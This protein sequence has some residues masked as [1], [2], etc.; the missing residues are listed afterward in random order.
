MKNK[1]GHYFWS[2]LIFLLAAFCLSLWLT[3]LPQGDAAAIIFWQIRLPR[4]VLAALVGASLAVSGVIFQAVLRNPLADPYLLGVS[5]GAGLG[6]A[7]AL[8]LGWSFWFWG[9]SAVSLLAL[10]GALAA[11]FI[12]YRLSLVSG[13]SQI[14]TLILAGVAVSAFLSAALALTVILSGKIWPIQ[15]W[16]M[17]NFTD[18]SWEKVVLVAPYFAVCF[19]L[20]FI[21]ARRLDVL[22]L[23]E[24]E[25]AALGAGGERVKIFF[26]MLGTILAAASVAAVGLIGF[27][28]L[29][30]PH[31]IRRLSGALNRRLISNS[32][33]AGA[34]F[35]V[36]ADYLARTIFSPQEL[37]VGL[38]T[39]F[40]GAPFFLYLLRREKLDA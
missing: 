26:I 36:L 12:I 31:V 15:L 16:L 37:P 4:V 34:V 29:V 25:A 13:T 14:T 27:V 3:G 7:L 17:G 32:A 23:G 1:P 21:Y 24:E 11:T 20:A 39:A 35:M 18:I 28:G 40:L 6:A 38:V 33:L 30:I 8:V 22:V 2:G 9:I 10:L 19:I 5:S